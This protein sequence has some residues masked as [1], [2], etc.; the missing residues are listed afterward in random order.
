MSDHTIPAADLARLRT[1]LHVFNLPAE[2]RA[3]TA[4]DGVVVSE[5][6]H[7]AYVILRGQATDAAFMQGVASVLGA[8]LPTQPAS[9]VQTPGGVVQWVSPDEWWVIAPRARRDALVASLNTALQGVFAQV[10]DNS[11]GHTAMRV[12]GPAHMLLLRHLGPY[13]FESLTVGKAVST[14][15]AKAVVS[16]CRTDEQGVVLLFRRSFADYFWRLLRRT[17]APY[18]LCV[19]QPGTHA[20]PV[21][22]PLL[23]ATH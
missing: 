14:V 17:A 13:D 7:L 18:G 3:P 19:T 12:T 9:L 1:P 20:D 2:S 6:P 4:K 8:S 22:T 15:M 5:L 16:V 23:P 21:F 10:V 11:G